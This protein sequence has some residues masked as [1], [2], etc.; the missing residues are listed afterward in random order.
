MMNA[1][2]KKLALPIIL[3]GLA[4]CGDSNNDDDT[5]A[6]ELG[7]IAEVATEAG[8]F[9]TLLAALE[10]TGLDATLI[11]ETG[12]FTVFAPNDEAFAKLGQA[13]IDSLLADPD[14][15]KEILL[16][17]VIVGSEIDSTAAI[18]VASDNAADNTVA[19]SNTDSDKT[20]LSLS[21]GKL[22]INFSEVISADV[23]AN[24]GI[25]H[26]IDTVLLPPTN[27]T[28]TVND[29]VDVAVANGSFTTLASLL[30]TANLV[31]TLKDPNGNFTVFAPTD[32]AFAKLDTDTLM[33]LQNDVDLLTEV[34]L[35]HVV[36]G[37]EINAVPALDAA[38]STVDMTDGG[39]IAVSFSDGDLYTNLSKVI[40]P[41]VDASNGMIH[42]ID[43]V[44]IPIGLGVDEPTQNIVETAV[45]AGNFT[46]LAAALTAT[47]LI[48]TLSDASSEFTVF[49]PTDDAFAELG[50]DT[51]N[52][53]L[54]DPDTLSKILLKHV[55][56]GSVDSVTALTFNG[57]DVTTLNGDGETLALDNIEGEVFVDDSKITTFDIKTTNGIIH[58]IDKVILLDE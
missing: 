16:Y 20:T 1:F 50:Q 22:F 55:L 23:N 40:I 21:G 31:N 14:T 30:G 57:K 7:N 37:A 26:V 24:N 44:L 19:M 28:E 15:L 32:A 36:S 10:A 17:H 33:T 35:Y 47:N 6:V 49:A 2:L 25:I 8:T 11:D 27:G 48:A 13:T 4:A 42:A 34:L 29:I 53:L 41:D 56:S 39:K 58:V 52:A 12:T 38:G 18:G 9:T 45:A 46:T 43:T 51:I 3:V 5:S 54:A